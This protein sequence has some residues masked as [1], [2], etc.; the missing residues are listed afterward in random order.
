MVV[1]FVI[2]RIALGVVSLHCAFKVAVTYIFVKLRLKLSVNHSVR[3]A[4]M[5]FGKLVFQNITCTW[6]NT[7]CNIHIFAERIEHF[8]VCVKSVC[9]V[10]FCDNKPV[11]PKIIIGVCS[12]SEA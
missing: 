4:Y 5:I 1:G 2:R 7:D 12:V 11:V 9:G 10:G 6:H 3:V 8:Y